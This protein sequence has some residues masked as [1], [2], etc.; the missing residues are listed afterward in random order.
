MWPHHKIARF[1]RPHRIDW[2]G[3]AGKNSLFSE[4]D[5]CGAATDRCPVVARCTVVFRGAGSVRR[6]GAVV[7]AGQERCCA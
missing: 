6:V 4:R 7:H 2:A 5:G 3:H 1:V